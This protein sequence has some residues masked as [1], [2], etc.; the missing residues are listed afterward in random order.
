MIWQ[1]V[2]FLIKKNH[3]Y[4]RAIVQAQL[5]LNYTIPA[6]L[7]QREADT[8]ALLIT[9]TNHKIWKVR[10]AKIHQI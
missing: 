6:S 9:I 5:S 4:C 2:D 1:F 3:H 8:I 7:S 10:N